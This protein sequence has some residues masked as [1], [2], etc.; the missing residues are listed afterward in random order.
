MMTVY[1]FLSNKKKTPMSCILRSHGISNPIIQHVTQV[2]SNTI[3]ELK[4]VSSLTILWT[5]ILEWMF[6]TQRSCMK[7]LDTRKNPS[8]NIAPYTNPALKT[9]SLRSLLYKFHSLVNSMTCCCH[10]NDMWY[11]VTWFHDVPSLFIIIVL[12]CSLLYEL[13]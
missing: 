4:E 10:K 7:F 5:W 9:W 13:F 2:K 11:W 3:L 6:K 8:T 1:Y 12:N